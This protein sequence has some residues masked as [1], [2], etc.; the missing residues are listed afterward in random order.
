MCYIRYVMKDIDK[1]KSLLK[2]DKTLVLVKDNEIIDSKLS[3]IKP[4]LT[5]LDKKTNLEGFSLADKIIGKAQAMLCVKAKIKEAHGKV[6]SKEGLRILKENNIHCSYDVLT[7]EIINRKG[8]DICPME[9]VVKNI[10]DIEKAYIALKEK[11]REM[12]L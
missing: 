4:L 2:D 11:V 8:T 10:E 5:F 3:G 7:D 9:K 12:K 6:M 1:A